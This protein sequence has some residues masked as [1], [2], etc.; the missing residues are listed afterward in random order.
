MQH[1]LDRLLA[2]YRDAA[3][4][5][6]DKGTYFERLAVAYL[7]NDPV[8]AELY[9]AVWPYAEWAKVQGL[10]GRD[11][12][13]DLVAKLRDE[14]GFAA[15]QCKFYDAAHRIQKSDIDS[16]M[17]A[18][19]KAHFQRRIIIDTTEAEW[20]VNAEDMLRGQS[21]PTLRIGLTDLRESPIDWAAF[22]DRGEVKLAPRKT[23]L[24]HQ[25]E[26]LDAVRDGLR[27]TERGKLIMACGTGKTFTS[28][29]IAEDM[30]GAGGI[31]L[32]L[33]PSLALMA[34]SVREWTNDAA[35]PLRSFAVCSDTQVGKRRMGNEDIAEIDVLDLAFPATTD[36]ARLVEEAASA[37]PDKMTVIFA[38]YQSI[39]V[40]S[41]AQRAGLPRFDLIICDEA[42]RTTGATL[43]GEDSSNFL[44]VHS[45]DF[46]QGR[47]RLYMTATPRIF[48]DNVKSKADQVDAVL[49][50]MDDEELFGKTLFYRGFS[51]AVQ[52]GL[53]TDYK[54]IVLA[55]DEG[56]VSSAIQRRLGDGTSELVLDDATKIIGCY[57][58]LTKKD[59]KGDVETDPLP[60]HRALAFCRDIKS[61]KLVANEFAAVVAE[62]L[63]SED[64]AEGDSPEGVLT[65][66]IEHVDGTFNAKTR[67]A[68]LDWLKGGDDA[69]TC[70]ILTNARCL[71]EGVDVPSLD[72]IMFLHP[73]KSQIDVVQSVG[74]VMRRAEGKKMGYVILPVGVPAGVPPEQALNDNEKYRVV[75]QI[76]NALRAHDD[77]FDATINKASLGQDVSGKIEIVGVTR[78]PELEA[79][80]AVVHDLPARAQPARSNIGAQ[81]H[82]GNIGA[83]EQGE[84]A[85]SVDEF[86]RAIMAKIV[87]KCGTR[88][89]WEDWATNI[90]EIAKNHIT[91]L[92]AI[93][94]APDTP[95]RQAFDAFLAELKDDLNDTISEGD[96]IEMLAQHII[97]RPVFE[98]L[99]EGHKFTSENP[100]S[101]AMQ[102]VLDVLNEQNLD[103]EARDLEKFYAS[104]RAR[105]EGLSE[106]HAKQRLIVELYDK[107][108][109]RAFPRTTEKLGIVYT[110]VEVVDFIIQSV[111]EVLKAEF[112]QTLG[113]EGVHIIDPF[114]GT[115]TFITRLLQSGLIAP[116][117]MERKY[118]H[119][120]HANEIVLLAYYIAAINIEAV[121][122]GIMD[123]DYVPFEGICLTDTFQ[124]YEKGDLISHYLPD[125]SE[126]R[127]RQRELDIR[128][129][130]ANPPYSKGQDSANDN[131]ANV[132]YECLDK[133]IR[134]T[135]S[136]S[137]RA[138][139]K[140]ALYDSY[141]RAI[142]W[143]SDRLGDAGGIMAYVTNAGW[144]DGNATDGLRKCLAEEFS[145][146]YVFHLR[147]NQ[148]TSGER[149]R[150][151]GG[152][153]FGSGSRAPIAITLF[154]K[155]PASAE[156]GKIFFHDIGDYLSQREKLSIVQRFGSIG[157][158]S[159]VDGWQQLSPDTHNDWL[160]KRDA[161]FSAFIKMGDKRNRNS[162]VL[163]ESYSSGV[164]TNR[165]AWC[166]NT[167]KIQL[168]ENMKGMIAF[169]NS[170]VQRY[171][172]HRAEGGTTSVE[173]F[174]D[175]D[176]KKISWDRSLRNDLRRGRNHSFN[177]S[178]VVLSAYRPFFSEWL[179][180]GRDMNNDVSQ[181]PRMFPTSDAENRVIW[182]TGTGASLDFTTFISDKIPDLQG[183]GKVQCF[184]LRIYDDVGR[185]SEAD[186]FAGGSTSY[187]VRDGITD[188]GLAHFQAAYPKEGVGKEDIFYYVYGLL[189][190]PAY[191][192][193]FA[194]N[195]FKELPR[196]PCVNK[197]EDFWRFSKAGR[198]LAD[199]HI[200][201]EN[202]DRWPVTIKEG[203]LRLANIK[204]SEA[205]YR[206]T[207][208]KF[209]KAGKEVDKSTV[210]YNAN[211]TMQDIPPEA[212]DYVVN[213]KSALE[214]VME[215]Q[216]V[217]IDKDSTIVND[218]NRYAIETVGN[219]AYPLELFQRVIT[220][221]MET[222]KI[223]RRLPK[224]ELPE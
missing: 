87:K 210:I 71:S 132:S 139:N 69:N 49:A 65:C 102:S 79:V 213:G 150:R 192:K 207:K 34:Q 159:A 29:K 185:S 80:T 198:E 5:E 93:L 147:G 137:S 104:V 72:A 108:F 126:R 125:N 18:S 50:S 57:K 201:Y 58:A 16:F 22:G 187:R 60:M 208:M 144:I 111:S 133:R 174:I 154:V 176:A 41:N 205:F 85:F 143:G 89:Y 219:P 204:N 15:I 155:N 117:E 38:T 99:F 6:R 183:T 40:I 90:A 146:L 122:H 138:V 44:K 193:R 109:R 82:E 98:T 88:D 100:V 169:F 165:D 140:T 43:S 202:V 105:A 20:S 216:V 171:A 101:R 152:K 66:E 47:K 11:T 64:A 168:E 75:W 10:D 223:V 135:Y 206:V 224:L 110:P 134:D 39:Q 19:G 148:R 26:A 190:S 62:Y 9:E 28:L 186:L 81:S 25:R 35:V 30:V 91:R 181:L 2:T 23:I 220:V 4:T 161:K 45:E 127:K 188:F 124:M 118:R 36:A 67:S 3:R 103:K 86:S 164:K 157:G 130:I 95:A 96:A 14:E 199:L 113:S 42:H 97:T 1:A 129:I 163:F 156:R 53:L 73:R 76:L 12:G 167:S 120:V 106:P 37:S 70:R 59:L 131:N 221:S 209:G 54:V 114:T 194:D 107:F 141:V 158:I 84:L 21:I 180:F 8:Q 149:S 166:F 203:D 48:G 17:S 68:R 217:K 151:E 175:T 119:E 13:I 212:Y 178:S 78:N 77:R 128:V 94:E 184:P 63:G 136:S 7:L 116:E 142:R 24:P 92:T 123:G 222:L 162:D 197:G 115:G 172:V 200:N 32:F 61:S 215:R 74:R 31:V 121:Y 195:L 170:E 52:N 153:I 27:E 189:H 46:I 179:Y 51:W 191:R 177:P 182:V 56:L 214:W 33:M 211:I 218:A 145:T 112:G 83:S 196:I 160:K 173:N 55:M